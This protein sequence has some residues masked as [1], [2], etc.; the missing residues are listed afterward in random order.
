MSYDS[1]TR[2]N[3][4]V[5]RTSAWL[6]GGVDGNGLSDAQPLR[7]ERVDVD[8]TTACQGHSNGAAP[9]RDRHQMSRSKAH[10]GRAS[11]DGERMVTNASWRHGQMWGTAWTATSS[12]CSLGIVPKRPAVS[13]R[14]VTLLGRIPNPFSVSISLDCGF[15]QIVPGSFSSAGSEG[16]VVMGSVPCHI[17]G[18]GPDVSRSGSV[19][20]EALIPAAY[21]DPRSRA[22]R[23]ARVFKRPGRHDHRCVT[24]FSLSN[25]SREIPT[26]F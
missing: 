14:H 19:N 9:A 1:Q 13:T 17:V 3:P 6:V 15:A 12:L 20:S 4:G 7:Y 26:R 21:P 22:R 10:P 11:I 16:G 18:C 24:A 23:Q 8:I 5:D 2:V 25:A